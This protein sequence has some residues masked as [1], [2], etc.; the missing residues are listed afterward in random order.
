ME[1][2][3]SFPEAIGPL[4]TSGKTNADNRRC[5]HS[6][7]AQRAVGPPAAIYDAIQS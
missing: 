1:G 5:R 7:N 3:V 2:E 4:F 6:A